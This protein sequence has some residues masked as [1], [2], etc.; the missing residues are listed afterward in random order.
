NLQSEHEALQEEATQLEQD[1]QEANSRIANVNSELAQVQSELTEARR[2]IDTRQREAAQLEEEAARIRRELVAEK[3]RADE[4][5]ESLESDDAEALRANVRELELALLRTEQELQN[6]AT[7]TPTPETEDAE[8]RIVL[9]GEVT[10]V[11]DDGTYLVINI[12][13]SAGAQNGGIVMLRRGPQYIGRA[14]I[15]EVRNDVSIAELMTGSS[16][17]QAGDYAITLN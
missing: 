9:R 2:I 15:T 10:E 4:L 5:A 17:V 11:S 13:E 6:I 1:L 8:Q 14:R 16:N 7:Q 3:R 12:G